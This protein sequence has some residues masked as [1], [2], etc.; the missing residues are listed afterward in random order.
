MIPHVTVGSYF[1]VLCSFY[2]TVGSR[3]FEDCYEPHTWAGYQY[4]ISSFQLF[5]CTLSKDEKVPE[6]DCSGPRIT[7]MCPMNF[8]SA[9]ETSFMGLRLTVMGHKIRHSQNLDRK[10]QKI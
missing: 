6:I 3:I 7:L 8:V 5:D 10:L 4:Q 9:I 2:C 1:T